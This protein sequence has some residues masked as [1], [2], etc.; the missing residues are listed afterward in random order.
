MSYFDQP[1]YQSSNE[2]QQTASVLGA[3]FGAP[4]GPIDQAPLVS[5]QEQL[6]AQFVGLARKY[7]ISDYFSKKL[8]KLIG[9]EIVLI[10]D[11][12]GSMNTAI[13]N[14]TTA[15]KTYTRW[16]ELKNIVNIITDGIDLEFLNRGSITGI[17]NSSQVND[18]FNVGPGGYTPI[19]R[20][21]RKVLKDKENVVKEQKLLIIILTDGQPTND[22]GD[23]DIKTLESVLR[24]ERTPINKI[25]VSFV[26][27]TDD[28]DSMEYL[29]NWDKVIPN[30]D[31]VDDYVNER[32]EIIGGT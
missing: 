23:V 17:T 11:D 14:K 29:N 28:D 15:Q 26:A 3:Q 27:C 5:Q 20:V 10:I 24:Y 8:K 1:G 7:E 13:D 30:V 18:I 16:D 21:L 19:S 22:K 6:D 4:G 32:K 25:F 2:G 12:S 9:Y 31:V